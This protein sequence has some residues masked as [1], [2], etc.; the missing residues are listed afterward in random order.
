MNKKNAVLNWAAAQED[1]L[2]CQNIEKYSALV[3]ERISLAH[4]EKN[5]PFLSCE[6]FENLCEQ[7]TEKTSSL[8]KYKH[9]LLLGIG[10][11]ALGA[12]AL[13]KAFAPEQDFPCHTG[14]SLWI[15]DNVDSTQTESYLKNLPAEDT[16]IVVISKSGTT[17][18]TITLYF[19]VKKWLQEKF[20]S[21]WQEHFFIITGNDGF[22]FDEALEHSIKS[23]PIP[24][25][26]GG[27]YSILSAVGLV[28]A[29]FLGIDIQSILLGAKETLAFFAEDTFCTKKL[30]KHPAFSFALWNFIMMQKGKSQLIFFNY[31]PAWKYFGE[32]FEQLWAES[33]GKDGKGS[34]PFTASGV[35]DQHS[36]NQMFLAGEKNKACLFISMPEQEKMFPF[37][38]PLKEPFS[39]LQDRYFS[40]L[41]FA[42]GVGTQTALEESGMPLVSLEIPEP[43]PYFAGKFIAFLG[44]AT[45]FTGWL[46]D[47][48]PIDQPAVE[49]G[50]KITRAW[51]NAQNS[52]LKS[53]KKTD[54]DAS[55]SEKTNSEEN[56]SIQKFL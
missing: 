31:I 55:N 1:I 8:K 16:C 56:V 45:L 17:I 29:H 28:P 7:I 32:W 4:S 21:S 6:Y 12:K 49:S 38:M 47:V 25:H 42:A 24:E 36:I 33:L 2:T 22:L 43:S 9:M 13:Q 19:L 5:L 41:L 10:G 14:K 44:A 3:A 26:L 54:S 18:E 15:A 51:F 48:N 30:T 11:S 20:P 50:K 40:D 35:T 34:L 52:Q 39:Y 27:R 23:L 53:A 46:L 37:H